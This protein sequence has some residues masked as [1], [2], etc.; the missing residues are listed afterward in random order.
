MKIEEG[1]MIVEL[2]LNNT[3][4]KCGVENKYYNVKDRQA[5]AVRNIRDV[6]P[7]EKGL[8]LTG[9]VLIMCEKC[10]KDAGLY[11]EDPSPIV[12]PKI[13]EQK[14]KDSI[15]GPNGKKPIKA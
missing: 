6:V 14:V 10:Y 1:D 13:D 8:M 5:F 15:V 11:L 4:F 3:V 7:T 12:I 9:N 2:R